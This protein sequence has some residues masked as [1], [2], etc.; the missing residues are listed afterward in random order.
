MQRTHINAWLALAAIGSAAAA[1]AQ[2]DAP[3][4]GAGWT[5]LTEAEEIIEARRVLMLQTEELMK[6][7]DAFT[8][9]ADA[10]PAALKAAAATIEAML[11]A[12]PHLFPPTTD[13][14]D[15]AELEQPTIAL[16]ALWQDFG[17]F[18]ELAAAGEAAAAA[19]VEAESVEA[20]RSAARTLRTTCDGCHA[21]FTEPYTPPVVTE[22]D[23]EFD[24]E[25]VFPED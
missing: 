6:P 19:M 20:L 14:Y 25:S 21:R 17:A 8:A 24:F 16:P 2:N 9:G 1:A 7:I 12:L 10:D 23:L 15:P 3:G 13:L 11:L 18:R 4:E 5:G 22:Q